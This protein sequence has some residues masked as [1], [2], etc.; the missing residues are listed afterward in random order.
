MRNMDG[1]EII[2]GIIGAFV[3]LMFLLA[4]CAI[5]AMIIYLWEIL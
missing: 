4:P 5:V 2:G 1:W 3:G